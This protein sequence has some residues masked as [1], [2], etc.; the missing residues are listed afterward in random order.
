VESEKVHTQTYSRNLD[1]PAYNFREANAATSIARRTDPMIWFSRVLALIFILAF[2]LGTPLVQRWL[3]AFKGKRALSMLWNGSVS[4]S[5]SGGTSC[6]R[7]DTGPLGV[8]SFAFI[9]LALSVFTSF[10]APVF[11]GALTILT[12]LYVGFNLFLAAKPGNCDEVARIVSLLSPAFLFLGLLMIFTAW[13]GPAAFWYFF[14][15]SAPFRVAFLMVFVLFVLRAYYSWAVTLTGAFQMP[16]TKSIGTMMLSQ[17]LLF[18]MGGGVAAW[19]GFEKTLTLLTDELML[20]PGGLSRILGITT[21]LGIPRNIPVV[22][23][24]LGFGLI[25]SGGIFIAIRRKEKTTI[26][27]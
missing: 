8:L 24:Y 11:V 16:A 1:F 13:R 18:A 14:W 26:H 19:F 25:L 3:P 2:L 4:P 7:A 5:T 23:M 21:H 22:V 15:T 9:I 6:E 10:A 17:G 27:P 20:L 12:I